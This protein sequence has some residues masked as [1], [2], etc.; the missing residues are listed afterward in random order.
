MHI[1]FYH[2]CRVSPWCLGS[3]VSPMTVG[4][5]H[6]EGRADLPAFK[7]ELMAGRGIVTPSKDGWAHGT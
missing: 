7:D 2:D 6:L 5:A 1:S 4:W 3:Y